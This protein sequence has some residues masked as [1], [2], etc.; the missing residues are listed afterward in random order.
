M[1]TLPELSTSRCVPLRGLENQLSMDRVATLLTVLP[2]GWR[3]L[4]DGQAIEKTF[5]F[6]RQ[7]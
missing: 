6:P 7:I 1:T 3:L 5:R 2:A 4:D